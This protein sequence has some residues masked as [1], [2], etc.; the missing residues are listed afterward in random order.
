MGLRIRHYLGEATYE[1]DKAIRNTADNFY[2]ALVAFL[3]KH[4]EELVPRSDGG[5]SVHAM[6]F[7][8]SPD[9]RNFGVVWFPKRGSVNGG[10]GK[11]GRHDVLVLYNLKGPG[12]KTA[13]DTRTSSMR[14][15]II[16][17]MA[18][19]LDPGAGKGVETAKLR[20]MGK[21]SAQK[22]YN[23]P[24]EWNAFWQEG[25]AKFERM[26]VNRMKDHP[27]YRDMFFGDG[28]LRAILD[29]V[30]KFWEPTYL[31]NMRRRTRR[32]FDKRLYQLWQAARDRGEL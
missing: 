30:H 23:D 9:A 21:L 14:D 28:S 11:A 20:D 25:A 26:L 16:H 24:S 2:H 32:R 15:V 5:F 6:N 8:R 29:R 19:Y 7:W 12:D 13:I 31:H 17:E 18:H 27:K 22:Y 1:R 10:I 4:Q 3:E